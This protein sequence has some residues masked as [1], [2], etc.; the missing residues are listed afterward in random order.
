MSGVSSTSRSPAGQRADRATIVIP[1]FN[2]SA[3]LPRALASIDEPEVEILVIDDA[4]QDGKAI[5]DL[6]AKDPRARLIAKDR[7]VNAAHS[8]ALGIQQASCDT[9]LFLDADDA[10]RPGHVARRCAMHRGNPAGVA[11]GRFRLN[12]GQREWDMPLSAYSGG[13]LETYI[14]AG[15]GDARSSTLSV[16][17]RALGGTTFDP[18]LRKHQDWGFAL[19]AWREGRGVM[20]DPE[21]GV[22]IHIGAATRMSAS[23]QV[24]ASLAFA[25]DHIGDVANRRRFL[26]ARLRTSL[27]HGDRHAAREFRRALLALAPRPSE[28]WGSAAMMVAAQ[29]GIAAPLHRLMAAHR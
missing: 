3:T 11:I 26:M 15:G 19:A 28:R 22:V 17:R 14:F 29:V 9:I 6:V 4:S 18:A 8:R 20:F 27:R 10:Y 23:A 16:S 2:A 21:Y 13:S 5:A 12:D 7:R 25:R 1:C 24:E